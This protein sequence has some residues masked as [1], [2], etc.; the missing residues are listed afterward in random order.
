[1]KPD[2]NAQI[3]YMRDM[4]VPYFEK[5]VEHKNVP[6]AQFIDSLALVK[7]ILA[8]LQRVEKLEKFAKGTDDGDRHYLIK[9]D[10]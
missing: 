10:K 9:D 8:S 2:L 7:A 6:I 1:M 4:I 5:L 3:E